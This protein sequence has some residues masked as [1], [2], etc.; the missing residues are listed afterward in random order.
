M[1]VIHTAVWVSDMEEPLDFYVDT[2]GLEKKLTHVSEDGTENVYVAGDGSDTEIQFR[3]DPT[4]NDQITPAGIDHLERSVGD[5][6][7]L[8]ERVMEADCNTVKEP[9]TAEGEKGIFRVAYV[10]DPDGYT[11]VFQETV[12]EF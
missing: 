10:E 5:T 12:E 2:L 6:D 8:F 11:V 4:A 3:Y 1:D 7:E 9:F